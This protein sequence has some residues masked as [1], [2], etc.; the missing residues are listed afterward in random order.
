MLKKKS[1]YK[2]YAGYKTVKIKKSLNSKTKL[3]VQ[4]QSLRKNIATTLYE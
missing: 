3:V 2:L 1:I 4:Q